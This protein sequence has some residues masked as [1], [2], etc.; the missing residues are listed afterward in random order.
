MRIPRSATR[1]L[2]GVLVLGAI[3]TA[4]QGAQPLRAL[5]TDAPVTA[6][7]GQRA[8]ALSH[9]F[10]VEP[11]PRGGYAAARGRDFIARTLEEMGVEVEIQRDPVNH[12]MSVSFVENVLGR[13]KGT[14]SSQTFGVTAHYDS[15]AWGPGAADDGAGVVVMPEAA[16]AL[17]CGPQ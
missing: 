1:V 5:P 11:R 2:V 13:I 15:V 7:S 8:I 6:F 4:W 17:K 16:R 9:D 10:A 14:D 12:G 3:A